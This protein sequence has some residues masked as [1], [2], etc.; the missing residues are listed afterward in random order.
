VGEVSDAPLIGIGGVTPERLPWV[1]AAGGHGVAVLSGI[2]SA[3][4]PVAALNS[5][6][7]AWDDA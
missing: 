3:P 2:W 5:Y 4:D 1:R 7:L 6:L